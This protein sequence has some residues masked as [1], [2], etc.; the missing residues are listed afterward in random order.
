MKIGIHGPTL[1]AAAAG[2]VPDSHPAIAKTTQILLN[3]ERTLISR[4]RTRI[5]R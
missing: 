5:T 4:N 3:G 2:E 1:I